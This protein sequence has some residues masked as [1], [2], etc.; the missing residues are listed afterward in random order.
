MVNGLIRVSLILILSCTQLYAQRALRLVNRGKIDKA[1]KISLTSLE[2]ARQFEK[3]FPD[4]AQRLGRLSKKV[5]AF[6]TLGR[7]SELKG[8]FA[9]AESWMNRA[10][11]GYLVHKGALTNKKMPTGFFDKLAKHTIIADAKRTRHDRRHY[12]RRNATASIYIR[13]G[14]LAS[15]K[16][17]LDSTYQAMLVS[18]GKKA[19]VAKSSYATYGEYY[20]EQSNFDSS[21]YFLEKYILELRSDPNY[22]DLTLKDL[23]DAYAGLAAAHLGNKNLPLAMDAARKAHK[24]ANHRFVRATDGHNYQSKIATANLIAEVYRSGAEYTEALSWNTRALRLSEEKIRFSSPDKLPVLATRA[25]IYWTLGDTTAANQCF[26]E[27]MDIFFSYTQNNFSYL[28]ESERSYFFRKNKSFLELTEGYYHYLYFT[29]NFKEP[30]ILERLYEVHLNNKGVLLNSA[31]KLLNVV[32]SKNDSSLIRR[33]GEIRLLKER[34]NLELASGKTSSVESL[35]REINRREKELRAHLALPTDKYLLMHDVISALP[36]S[37]DLVDLLKCQVYQITTSNGRKILTRT[38]SSDYVYFVLNKREKPALIRN[39]LSGD[40]LENR[41]YRAYQNYARTDIRDSRVFKGYFEP[42]TPYLKSKKIIVSPDGIFNLI[43]P[44]VIFDGN[45]HLINRYRF[46]SVVSAKDLISTDKST[47]R[48][49]DITLV[50][51]PDYNTHLKVY[52]TKPADLPGT[53][54]ELREIRN[55]VEPSATPVT[56]VQAHANE[57]VLK[58]LT[59]TSVLHF[60]T[61]GFFESDKVKDPMHTSGLVLAIT[62]SV[63]NRED[64]YLTAFEASNLD[65]KNTFLVVLSACE[66]GQGAVEEGEGV[67]GLQRAFQVAGVRYIVMS[68]F[69]VDDEVTV[70]LMK[71]FYQNLMNGTDVLSAF[72]QAQM[73][74]K[75]NHPRPVDWGAF[76]LKGY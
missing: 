37:T 51:W 2:E 38:D 73:H 5:W 7:I 57:L 49:K 8:D 64:G 44:E 66:T 72:R 60:A 52:K 55:I 4:K 62:D 32:Y 15:A 58:E 16:K 61:H 68:L 35:D 63:Q 21:R 18:Y 47:P 28:S 33:Y 45:T 67:W 19:S 11:S 6:H 12:E 9:V 24:Y 46:Y 14:E 56:Y 23:S 34:K 42:L 74:V 36:D 41:Y 75:N 31:S 3:A 26:R 10:D 40:E 13:L 1:E 59:S 54:R 69:K 76:I 30:Y 20:L 70:T 39:P 50:G 29:K 27:L 65:L 22:Y 43:N 53:E 25:Q 17:I 48:L 71:E